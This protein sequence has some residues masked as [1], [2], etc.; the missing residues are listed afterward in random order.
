MTS[1]GI[2]NVE[3][4]V[5][6][7]RVDV[8]AFHPNLMGY[9]ILSPKLLPSSNKE[10][11]KKSMKCFLNKFI[12]CNSRKRFYDTSKVVKVLNNL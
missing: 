11:K 6:E 3:V 10:N 9:R 2:K 4:S 8:A 7:H 1:H 5:N 12:A